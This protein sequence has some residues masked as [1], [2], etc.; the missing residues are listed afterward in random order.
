MTNGWRTLS[1]RERGAWAFFPAPWLEDAA[2]VCTNASQPA[3]DSLAVFTADAYQDFEA[4]FEFRW[5]IQGS[6]SGF[7][8]RGRHARHYYVA[9]FPCTGQQYR[10]GHFWAAI[11]K[12]DRSGW[13][14]ILRTEIVPG[15]PSEIGLW[16]TARLKA[17]G[18]KF[19]LWVDDRPFPVVTDDTYGEPGYV[20]LETY[21]GRD[22]STAAPQFGDAKAR[23]GSG[24]SFR[25]V[26]IRGKTSTAPPWNSNVALGAHWQYPLPSSTHGTRQYVSSLVQL[27]S[28]E[29]ILS[30]TASDAHVTGHQTPLLLRSGDG[31]RTWSE[32]QVLPT[33]LQGAALH[34]VD[35]HG[36]VGFLADHDPPFALSIVNSQD[37]GRTWTTPSSIGCLRF[38]SD[39]DIAHAYMGKIVAL[40]DGT[41]LRF[42]YTTAAGP[43][44]HSGS[45]QD[46]WRYIGPAAPGSFSFCVRSDDQGI[47]WS[48]PAHVDGPNP[49][50]DMPVDA[51]ETASETSAC[52][53]EP[54]RILALIRPELSPWMWECWSTDGGHTWAPAGRGHFP[55]Y[56]CTD[57]ITATARGALVIAGRHPGIAAQLSLDGGMSWQAT[58]IDTPFYANGAT[59]EVEPDV[60]L[61]VY[62][63]KYSDPRVR[64]QLLQVNSDRLEPAVAPPMVT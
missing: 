45:T 61:Y 7:V 23:V 38:A 2:G 50:P 63:G 20:G 27:G 44:L 41:L 32:A 42:G 12:V 29:V 3:D 13:T 58:R 26:R 24:N 22:P 49:R 59:V 33:A 6:D 30:L 48:A 8:F 39:L 16:H 17:R 62:D 54:N 9:H 11:S 35:G 46:G 25:N 55:M 47:T 5:D 51:R 43:S 10:S 34:A 56:A 21:N 19:Y 28:G 1:L 40:H 31:G 37:G 57:A 53:V 15:I 64:A 60:V 52:E 14:R 36:L 4:E 18:C